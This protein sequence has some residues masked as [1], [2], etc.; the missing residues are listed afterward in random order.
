M[1]EF[2]D[3]DARQQHLLNEALATKDQLKDQ[4]RGLKRRLDEASA[5]S[6]ASLRRL[7]EAER[8]KVHLKLEIID[9][10]AAVS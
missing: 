8:S 7:S 3:L 6:D 2:I 5:N 1:A 4:Q 9:R 10:K